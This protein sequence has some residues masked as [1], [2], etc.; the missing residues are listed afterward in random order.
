MA[1]K[2]TDEKLSVSIIINGNQAQKELYELEKS[3]RKLN[4]SQAELRREKKRLEQQGKTESARYKE[5]TASIKTNTQTINA[6]KL[7]MQELQKQI[8]LTGLSMAQLQAKS[9]QLRNTLR[10]LIPGSAD[11]KRYEA[12]LKQ[13]TLRLNELRGKAN[14]AKLSI[15]GIA[16]SFNR[17][18]ALAFSVIATLTG[19]ALSISKILDINGKL[20]DAQADVRK[21]TGLTKVEVDELTK[22][23]GLMKTRTARIELLKLAEEGGRL[24]IEGV[25]NI[26]AFVN[27]A[28]Q[29]KVALGDDLSETQIREVGK[30]VQVYKVGEATGRDFEGAMLSLGSAI[31]EVAASGS[32]QAGFLVEFLKRTAGISNQV[33][34]SAADNIGYAATFDEIGQTAEVTGTA[35]NKIWMDMAKDASTYAKIA[36]LSTKDFSELLE[37]DANKAMI[38]FLKGL[39]GNSQGLQMMV[40]KLKDLE[41]GGARGVQ[42]LAAISGNLHILEERQKT[43]NQ[44]LDEATSLTDE[45]NVKN[46]NL[47]ATLEKINKKVMGW[48]SS[49]TFINWLAN[50]VEGFAVLIGATE[51]VDEK[52]KKW[53]NT[54]INTTKVLLVLLATILSYN[55]G[56]KLSTLWSTRNTQATLLYNIVAKARSVIEAAAIL[57]TQ[58]WAAITMLLT[59][60]VKGATQ[61]LRVM[62]SV[63]KANPF[64]LLLGVLVAVASAMILFRDNTENAITSA[65]ILSDVQKEV[66]SNLQKEKDTLES[67]LKIAKDETLSKE[68]REKAI[69]KINE[70][71]PEYLGN[72]T[73]E[74]LY[75]SETTKKINEYVNAL[76]RKIKLQVLEQKLSESYS[77]QLDVEK[78]NVDEYLNKYTDGNFFKR[79]VGMPV[80]EATDVD[81]LIDRKNVE[82][83]NEDEIQADLKEQIQ[84]LLKEDFS[85]TVDQVVD[86]TVSGESESEKERE[87]RQ[88]EFEKRLEDLKKQ[89]SELQTLEDDA[90]NERLSRLQDGYEKERAVLQNAHDNR[91]RDL[92]AQLVSEADIQAAQTKSENTNLSTKERSFWIEQKE[93]WEQKN[94]V[95]NQ[96]IAHEEYMLGINLATIQEKY[97]TNAIKEL[98]TQYARQKNLRETEFYNEIASL[99]SLAQAKEL[100]RGQLSERELAQITTLEQAKEALKTTHQEAELKSQEEFILQQIEQMERVIAGLDNT[101]GIDFNLLDEAQ[102]DKILQDLELIKKAYAELLA[103]KNGQKTEGG[104]EF[105]SAAMAVFGGTDVLGFSIEQWAATF[106]NLDSLQQKLQ[107]TNMIVSGLQNLWGKYNAYVSASENASL[108]NYENGLDKRKASLKQQLDRGYINQVQYRNGIVKLEDDV[109]RKRAELEYKQAKREKDMAIIGAIVNVAKGVTASLSLAPPYSFIAAGITAAMG[110]LEIATIRKQPLPAKGFEDGLYPDHVKREQDGKLFKAG[111][112]GK[113]RSGMVNKPTY[114]LAGENYKPEMVIDSATYKR[115]DPELRS[116]LVRQIR[117]I[118]GFED[119]YYSPETQRIEVPIESGAGSD[120]NEVLGRIIVVLDRATTVLD[121]MEKNGISAIVSSKDY[122]SVRELRDATKKLEKVEQKSKLG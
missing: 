105:S 37:K 106:E 81:I 51:S 116:A 52:Q 7:K 97:Y 76:G 12:E 28:N 58:S 6:N 70:I 47:A 24:G 110:A 112:G 15:S 86:S 100:L 82:L 79:I 31:N 49:E 54:L 118:K 89:K 73:L 90:E 99:E 96:R 36:G 68:A 46:N 40:G 102:K 45:Y 34:L 13:V 71:S 41:V 85:V 101:L 5:V 44:A 29:M 10:H 60:N 117:G 50:V 91:L 56:L 59:G 35:M 9:N 55:A 80:S 4:E 113:T 61:A 94:E 43:S 120:S 69:R 8:G 93:V 83:K 25:D 72:I 18:Q 33:K 21:T 77:R 11:Y 95:I 23:F 66:N 88:K 22:S 98:E 63:V 17:Y 48:F 26:K 62:N 104:S 16:D 115:L 87:K 27:V 67:L 108:R 119:G 114:F 20:S 65:R 75:T 3:T 42:A 39:N 122:R 2:I 109:A 103:T 92:E 19:L 107:A 78:K 74:N 14:Q 121:N 64:G 84:G 111:Y 1:K 53:R 30:M 38:S 57:R 32:N